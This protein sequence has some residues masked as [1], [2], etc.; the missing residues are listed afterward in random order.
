MNNQ[1]NQRNYYPNYVNPTG[2]TPEQYT[3]YM[4]AAVAYQQQYGGWQQQMMI[5]M[6]TLHKTYHR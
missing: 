1:N 2:F 4:Q 5:V 3:Q 6:Q